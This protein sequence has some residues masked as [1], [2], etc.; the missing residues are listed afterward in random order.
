M[1]DNDPP[2]GDNPAGG[3]GDHIPSTGDGD[4]DPAGGDGDHDPGGGDGDHEGSRALRAF[5]RAPARV[6]EN[7]RAARSRQSVAFVR[8]MVAH[9][10][11]LDRRMGI[12]DVLDQLND[13]VDVSDP[14]LTHPNALHAFQTAEMLRRDGQPPWLQL[15]GLIHDAGKIMHLRGS[16]A[17]GT[18]RNAQWAMVGDTFVVGCELPAALVYPEFNALHP[19]R[20]DLRYRSPLGC[21]RPGCGMDRVQCSWGHDEY[22]YRVLA[23]D[24]NPHALPEAALYIVRY[25]SLYAY[26]RDGAYAQFMD[27]RD[28]RL[29]PWLRR[30]N[31]YDLYSKVDEDMDTAALRPYYEGLVRQF[32]PRGWWWL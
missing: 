31:R 21:Y 2:S 24:K 26:H 23:S 17:D 11:P 32:F 16:D 25:H 3:D 30:F 20:D 22:L 10:A 14:D 6:R 1:N 28:R 9:F 7:Y 5:D 15:V 4:H 13:L 8:R 27:D 12:W 18:G 29:L 19:D